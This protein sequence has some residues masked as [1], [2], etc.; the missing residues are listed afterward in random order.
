MTPV[1]VNAILAYMGPIAETHRDGFP[2]EHAGSYT[3]GRRVAGQSIEWEAS[4]YIH[5]EKG[6]AWMVILAFV[7]LSGIGVAIWF[8]L[9]MFAFLITIMAAAF[10]F[11]A[12][13]KPKTM[14]YKLS[15]KGLTIGGKDFPMS[16]FSAFGVIDD[17]AL[18]SI[19]LIPTKRLA[20][21]IMIY[22]AE[23]DGE[24][25][26]DLLGSHIP[27]EQMQPDLMDAIMRR[28]RF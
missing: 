19:R 12:V 20:P 1:N 10:G 26:V 24:E 28:L 21:A 2:G 9:W 22:F 13:R 11:Y 4:E 15:G 14:H 27:M 25:I 3:G 17:G 16:D 5:H 23:D 18:L 8:S 7:A 6:A